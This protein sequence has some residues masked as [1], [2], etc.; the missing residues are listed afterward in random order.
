MF[1]ANVDWRQQVFQLFQRPENRDGPSGSGKAGRF[2]AI[3]APIRP[4]SRAGSRISITG[5]GILKV[6]T[7]PV[8]EEVMT[9][10]LPWLG[11]LFCFLILIT[12]MPEV[13]L[14]LPNLLD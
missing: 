11:I 4:E 5:M 10:A 6:M 8:I 12:S 9:A 2:P 13:S 14:F 3:V 1:P 7:L